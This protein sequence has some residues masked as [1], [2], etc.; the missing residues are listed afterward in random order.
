MSAGNTGTGAPDEG[1]DPFAYLYRPEGGQ[2][3][4]GP[5]Q[6]GPR[7]PSY[8]QVRPVGERTFGGQ[9]GG[10]GYP[11]QQ[12]GGYGYPPQQGYRQPDA[13]YAAPESRP[14]GAPPFGPPDRRR[15]DPEP[16]RNGLL[17]GAIAVV[18][19]VA[20]GVGAAIVFSNG[21]SEDEAGG[22]TTPT[23]T[24]DAGGDG[25]DGSSPSS[26]PSEDEEDDG[27]P[28]TEDLHDL[29]LGNGAAVETSIGGARSADG[30]YIAVQ[31]RP[32][33]SI[34]WTFEMPEA[35]SYRFY[36]GY[37]TTTD[38]QGMSFS[39]NGEP[40]EDPVDMKDYATGSDEMDTSWVKTYNLV[41]LQEGENTIELTCTSSCD[42]NID[43][44]WITEDTDHAVAPWE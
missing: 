36:T 39:V 17:I 1:D 15:P 22:D 40:R 19:A 24:G 44:F 3:P 33:A 41:D 25:G 13:H 12:G 7:Q 9:Q 20:L 6:Q 8:H 28:A 34:S 10:Y 43:A 26:S 16:R 38:G 14:G 23:P 35:G 2:A 42:V 31:G 11:P 37:A 5:P 29:T 27:P 30:S 18:L 4:Q 32:H 21:G